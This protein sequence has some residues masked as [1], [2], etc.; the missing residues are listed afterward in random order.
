MCDLKQLRSLF[1]AGSCF[2]GL[3][4]LPLTVPAAACLCS[5]LAQA[6]PRSLTPPGL[7]RQAS[8]RSLTP[9]GLLRQ[10]SPHSLT[11][12]GL[13]RRVTGLSPELCSAGSPQQRP[14][15]GPHSTGSPQTGISQSP[16]PP[17]LLSTGLSQ[18][19]A[20]L[21]LL[22]AGLHGTSRALRFPGPR[23]RGVPMPM[24]SVRCPCVCHVAG[25]QPRSH[26]GSPGVCHNPC[27]G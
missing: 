14:V 11:P 10:A 20:P 26:G 13:L 21:G 25:S 1:G 22:S 9:P 7:L 24:W 23:V 6:C 12:P 2:C 16:A 8:P 3:G 27:S 17:G 5:A 15:P 4:P 19:L 18:G